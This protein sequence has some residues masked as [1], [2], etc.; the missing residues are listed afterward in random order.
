MAPLYKHISLRV[1]VEVLVLGLEVCDGPLSVIFRNLM[2]LFCCTKFWVVTKV[3]SIVTRQCNLYSSL[4]CLEPCSVLYCKGR[5][6][7]TRMLY[8]I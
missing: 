8:V 3:T 5:K 4:V 2:L 7:S 1:N 6:V